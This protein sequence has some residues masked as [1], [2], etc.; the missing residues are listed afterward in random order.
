MTDANDTV[1]S[2]FRTLGAA[3]EATVS[4]L[5]T[6]IRPASMALFSDSVPL[7]KAPLAPD[8]ETQTFGALGGSRHIELQAKPCFFGSDCSTIF[9]DEVHDSI[10]TVQPSAGRRP[11]SLTPRAVAQLHFMFTLLTPHS[12][13]VISAKSISSHEVL[14]EFH[15]SESLLPVSVN[16]PIQSYILTIF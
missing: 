14:R 3:S 8:I 10:V 15:D 9:F 4:P 5:V 2:Q 6:P 12:G 1:P 7:V 16:S 13:N 11:G